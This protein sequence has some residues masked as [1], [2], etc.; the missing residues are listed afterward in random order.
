MKELNDL[1]VNDSISFSVDLLNAK[2]ENDE[3]FF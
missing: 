3:V 2:F 1:K